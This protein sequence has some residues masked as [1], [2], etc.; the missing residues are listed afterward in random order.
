MQN[1]QGLHMKRCFYCC[2]PAWRASLVFSIIILTVSVMVSQKPCVADDNRKTKPVIDFT[3]FSL[4]ELKNVEII[5]ASKKPEK[6]SEI[7]S[8]VF[9]ITREDIRRSGSVSIADALRMAPGVQ[10]A[11]T[12]LID[13]AISIRSLNE[14]FSNNLLLHC[15]HYF[16]NLN[17]MYHHYYLPHQK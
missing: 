10:V 3:T 15:F 7:P 6:V 14:D 13:W 11:R 4:E 9:V 5:S 2:T 1:S 16:H 17:Y 8:A 12:D